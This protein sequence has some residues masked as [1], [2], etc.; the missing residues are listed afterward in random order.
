MESIKAN[1]FF[2]IFLLAITVVQNL[3]DKDDTS[4]AQD[5]TSS[6]AFLK[7]LSDRDLHFQS[8]R[9][10]SGIIFFVIG[11]HLFVGIK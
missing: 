11:S 1:I 6:E 10:C 8:L 3:L 2:Y 4:V 5:Q 9:V 7:R